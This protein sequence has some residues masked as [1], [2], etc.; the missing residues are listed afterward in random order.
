[1]GILNPYNI[2]YLLHVARF[3]DTRQRRLVFSPWFK[4]SDWPM[5]W[6]WYPDVR[7]TVVPKREQKAFQKQEANC[8]PR[9]DTTYLGNPCSLKTCRNITCAVSLVE[10]SLGRRTKL[11]ILETL[12]TTV[13]TV[14]LPSE[15]GKPV[16]KSR[17]MSDQGR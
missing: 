1:M 14:V 6:G 3:C 17:V 12:P 2:R 5:T 15:G 10:G 4:R 8:S 16:I 9:S 11:T 7:L 13:K